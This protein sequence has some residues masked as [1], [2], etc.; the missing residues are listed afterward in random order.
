MRFLTVILTLGLTACND[1][2]GPF[3]SPAPSDVSSI[4]VELYNLPDG[5]EDI[6]EFELPKASYKELLESLNGSPEDN[7]NSKWQVLGNIR[8]T[9][10]TGSVD[11]NL[12]RTGGNPGAFK[13]NGKYFRGGSDSEFIQLREAAGHRNP[14][15]KNPRPS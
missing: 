4:T 14:A 9:M 2:G 8:I 15:T 7:S 5:S 12:F 3:L 6:P 1:G 13:A 11:V 10:R